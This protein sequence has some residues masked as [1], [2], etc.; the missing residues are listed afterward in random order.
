ME[1]RVAHKPPLHSA[2]RRWRKGQ[3][4]KQGWLGQGK[5]K[6]EAAFTFSDHC[7]SAEP[8]QVCGAMV[9]A[10]IATRLPI[11]HVGTP[12]ASQHQRAPQIIRAIIAV[13]SELLYRWCLM[14]VPDGASML[15]LCFVIGAGH[16]PRPGILVRGDCRRFWGLHWNG[17]IS[18]S[19]KIHFLIWLDTYKNNINICIFK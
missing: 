7:S 5:G 13:A 18:H 16:F 6:A 3:K 17:F 8:I 11:H 15:P 10:A 4:R 12:A 2:P 19:F 1:S 14:P 9:V